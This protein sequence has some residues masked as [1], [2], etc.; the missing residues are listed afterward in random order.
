MLSLFAMI[1]ICFL[2]CVGPTLTALLLM[3]EILVMFSALAHIKELAARGSLKLAVL[4]NMLGAPRK[5]A[6]GHGL[7]NWLSRSGLNQTNEAM[8][9]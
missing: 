2:Q 3:W 5:H 9:K 8:N 7:C 4:E 6:L 1:A